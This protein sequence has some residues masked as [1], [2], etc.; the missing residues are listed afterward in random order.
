MVIGITG[1]VGAGKSRILSMLEDRCSC[2]IIYA[3]DAAKKLQEPGNR[4]YN[5]IVAAFGNDVLDADKKIDKA[6]LAEIIF[7]DSK[8]RDRI[9]D[10]IHPAVNDYITDVIASERRLGI[11]DFLFIEAALLIECGYDRICDELWYVFASE[12]V[13]R[14]RL[15]ESRS[16]SDEK[17]DSIF[18]AQ[19]KEEVFRKYC[20]E[21]IDNN[22]DIEKTSG[23]ITSV[24]E[25][26]KGELK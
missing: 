10:I 23:Q 22:G 18:A 7:D 9:N 8:A 17:I 12:D 3:D 14:E 13:R 16:Y 5:E 1:G 19:L 11:R 15:K 20:A 26:K 24:I 6:A 2:R 4:C 25:K 21:I